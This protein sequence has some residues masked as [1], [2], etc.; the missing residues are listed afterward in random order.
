MKL[1]SIIVLGNGN[2]DDFTIPIICHHLNG[3][4]I[5]GITKP[6]GKHR[7]ATLSEIPTYI[8]RLKIDKLVLVMDQ[9]SDDLAEIF[10]QIGSGLSDQNIQFKMGEDSDRFKHYQC[11]YGSRTFDFIL[12]IN[13]L[14]D[15]PTEDSKETWNSFDESLQIEILNR[16]KENKPLSSKIFPQH[17]NGLL[18]LEG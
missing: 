10:R 13:G 14:N 6:E 2:V 12:I 15:I 18:L 11:R 16:L 17:F 3:N 1:K 4:K 9:E 8:S 5:V 7:N